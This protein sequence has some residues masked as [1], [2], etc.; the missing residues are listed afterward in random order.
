M[1]VLVERCQDQV[2]GF[3]SCSDRGVITGTLPD[4]LTKLLRCVLVTTLVIR[5]YTVQLPLVRNAL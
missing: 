1:N 5:E 3:L 2:T 4:I